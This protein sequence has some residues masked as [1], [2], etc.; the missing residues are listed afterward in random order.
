MREVSVLTGVF[1]TLKQQLE[2]IKIEEVKDSNYIMI[3]DYPNKPIAPSNQQG[4]SLFLLL[5]FLGMLLGIFLAFFK[6]FTLKKAPKRI[7][8]NKKN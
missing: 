1:T 8:K 3:I 5:T 2:M 7:N 4:F 6:E